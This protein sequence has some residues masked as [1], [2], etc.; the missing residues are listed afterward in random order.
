MT[1]KT[2]QDKTAIISCDS[3]DDPG[4]GDETQVP[5]VHHLHATI[6]DVV[7]KEQEAENHAKKIAALDD[8]AKENALLHPEQMPKDFDAKVGEICQRCFKRVEH[9]NPTWA[10]SSDWCFCWIMSE[11][12]WKQVKTREESLKN[13]T[14]ILDEDTD[15]E[16]PFVLHFPH[17]G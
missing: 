9:T 2:A 1:G 15:E 5:D 8:K 17:L 4:P 7:E 16:V 13:K 3:D 14:V 6:A 12:L 11:E 10:V